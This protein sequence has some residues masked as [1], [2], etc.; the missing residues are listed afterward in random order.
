[1]LLRMLLAMTGDDLILLLPTYRTWYSLFYSCSR[2]NAS[3]AHFFCNDDDHNKNTSSYNTKSH[4]VTM[5]SKD[6]AVRPIVG[7]LPA[8]PRPHFQARP[9]V[10]TASTTPS[11]PLEPSNSSHSISKQEQRR[12]RRRSWWWWK[13]QVGSCHYLFQEKRSP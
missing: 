7:N 6:L 12:R 11:P 4:P 9:V 10:E 1:M 13:L 2:V 3:S 5:K 8:T